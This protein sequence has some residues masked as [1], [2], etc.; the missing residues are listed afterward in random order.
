MYSLCIPP[1]TIF[2]NKTLFAIIGK[3][4][5]IEDDSTY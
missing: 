2:S 4:Y 1:T 3:I 5:G